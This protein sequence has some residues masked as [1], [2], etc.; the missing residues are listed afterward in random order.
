MSIKPDTAQ[1]WRVTSRGVDYLELENKRFVLSFAH[2]EAR[3][4]ESILHFALLDAVAELRSG[5]GLTTA[6]S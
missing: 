6:R 4:A 2:P 3:V 5:S 1:P